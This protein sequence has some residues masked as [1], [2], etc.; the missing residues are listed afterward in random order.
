MLNNK[1]KNLERM[2][3]ECKNNGHNL[4]KKTNEGYV[5]GLKGQNC[6]EQKVMSINFTNYYICPFMQKTL[7]HYQK[8]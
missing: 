5:C 8:W 6:P 1:Q 3:E 4:A 2:A 7:D